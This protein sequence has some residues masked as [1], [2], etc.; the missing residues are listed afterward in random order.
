MLNKTE[1]SEL[2]AD[3]ESSTVEFMPDEVS[4]ET[5]AKAIVALSNS[6]GG[7]VLLGVE[8]DG[9][10]CGVRHGDLE[11]W[12][13]DTVFAHH[14]HPAIDPSYQQIRTDDGRHVAVISLTEGTTKPY[15]VRSQGHE[16][17]Y[18]RVG[19][20]SRLATR[21]QQARLFQ[22]GG[23]L[24]VDLQPVPRSTFEDLSMER[25]V[26]HLTSVLRDDS[27]PRN[28]EEWH[29][30]LCDLDIMVEHGSGP[31]V[32]TIGGLVLF[33][34]RPRRFLRH[35]GVR[36]M[37]F[38][39]V[40]MSY[41]ALDDRRIDGPLI[42][43]KREG[44]DG[45]W[46]TLA[47]GIV[48]S[49]ESAMQPFVSEESATVDESWSG[50]RSWHYTPAAVRE[51]L[52]NALAHRDWTRFE[53]VQVVRYADRLEILSPGALHGSMT[54]EKMIGGRRSLRNSMIAGV[55]QC[56]GNVD[57]RRMGV[58]NKIV[59][60]VTELSGRAPVFRATEDDFRVTMFRKLS[61]D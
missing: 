24:R 51:A 47:P 29:K 55:L 13:I 5:L 3:G 16:D 18:F 43:L 15:V 20:T 25:L 12:V 40:E 35:A 11:H 60:P 28:D 61:A 32:C 26:V 33:G 36:W 31:P 19:S 56:Y 30:R 14:V 23:M 8:D 7:H 9:T 59:P 1:L 37:A 53:E 39:G 10:V 46:E 6:R 38:D 54:V 34:H 21:E 41:R 4:P 2:I 44:P 50:S 17:I 27:P 52:L 45:N 49:V 48:E 58:R 22:A 42:P 57:S